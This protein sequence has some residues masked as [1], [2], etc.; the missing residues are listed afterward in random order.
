[1]EQ[2]MF[3][4]P[5]RRTD[6]ET[7]HQHKLPDAKLRQMYENILSIFKNNPEGITDP[8]GFD[9]YLKMFGYISP[10]GYRTRRSELVTK[11]L[12]KDSGRRVLGTTN[13]QFI[14]WSL[15]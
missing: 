3:P 13:R 4:L 12:V 2:M 5:A 10:S 7:S 15:V 14:V 1:M 8:Q 11:G 9:I 6:P